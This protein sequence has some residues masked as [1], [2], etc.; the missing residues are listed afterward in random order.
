MFR[1]FRE[2]GPGAPFLESPETFRA[3]IPSIIYYNSLYNITSLVGAIRRT[4][5]YR[6]QHT[7]GMTSIRLAMRGSS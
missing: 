3:F 2:T 6:P 7:L 5:T 1:D 4:Y